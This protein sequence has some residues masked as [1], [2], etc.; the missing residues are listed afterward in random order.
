VLSGRDISAA[1]YLQLQHERRLSQQAMDGMD[2]CVFPTNPIAAIPVN[3]VDEDKTPLSLLGRFVN[4]L[5]LCS[6]AVPMGLSP[7]GLPVSMQIIGRP[8]A[9]GLVLR[10]AHAYQQVS[11]WHRLTPPGLPS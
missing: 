10:T 4:L 3:E 11:D 6:V 1:G 5:D 2:L 9:E 7:Q 8:H